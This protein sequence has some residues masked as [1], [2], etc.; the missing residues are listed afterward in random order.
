[1]NTDRRGFLGG[2]A[3]LFSMTAVDDKY[4]KSEL[5]DQ[6]EDWDNTVDHFP[7]C[8]EIITTGCYPMDNP[9][10]HCCSG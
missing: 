6:K 10:G 9:N 2:V 8:S 7:A 1:M 3:A 4:F 5:I